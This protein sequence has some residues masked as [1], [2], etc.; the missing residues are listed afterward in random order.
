[1]PAQPV[2]LFPLENADDTWRDEIFEFL[3]KKLNEIILQS[4]MKKI[5][6][7][8]PAQYFKINLRYWGNWFPGL[9]KRITVIY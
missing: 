9:S 6:D 8:T 4:D 1:M 7:I 5:E 2:Q 3:N